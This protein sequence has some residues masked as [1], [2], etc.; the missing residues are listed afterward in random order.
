MSKQIHVL[1]D[2]G[3]GNELAQYM[4]NVASIESMYGCV[5][6][7][8]GESNIYKVVA[9]FEDAGIVE[10]SQV[11]TGSYSVKLNHLLSKA[12][13]EITP[14]VHEN[15]QLAGKAAKRWN[16][17]VVI[18]SQQE[19]LNAAIAK[20]TAPVKDAGI[21]AYS[22][23][24]ESQRTQVQSIFQKTLKLSEPAEINMITDAIDR[25][26][27]GASLGVM[28]KALNLKLD[29]QHGIAIYEQEAYET[30]MSD[31]MFSYL[32]S[33]WES[34]QR[35]VNAISGHKYLTPKAFG[36]ILDTARLGKTSKMSFDI[37]AALVAVGFDKAVSE[38]NAN[39]KETTEY[40]DVKPFMTGDNVC[41][42]I[43]TNSRNRLAGLAKMVAELQDVPAYRVDESQTDMESEDI[44]SCLSIYYEVMEE[45]TNNLMAFIFLTQTAIRNSTVINDVITSIDMVDA[46]ITELFENVKNSA[47]E[48]GV[49]SQEGFKE[50]IGK[51]TNMFN[52]SEVTKQLSVLSDKKSGVNAINN[53]VRDYAANADTL[54][55]LKLRDNHSL[56]ESRLKA[57]KKTHSATISKLFNVSINK[58]DTEA[59]F[60]FMTNAIFVTPVTPKYV[61][62]MGAAIFD[63][64]DKQAKLVFKFLTDGAVMD[65]YLD[66]PYRGEKYGFYDCFDVA[67]SSYEKLINLAMRKPTPAIV[68]ET[69]DNV[70]EHFVVDSHGTYFAT[71]GQLQKLLPG[72]EVDIIVPTIY[73]SPLTGDRNP[74][75]YRNP[76]VPT[77]EGIYAKVEANPKTVLSLNGIS[78]NRD[79]IE[80]CTRQFDYCRYR[81]ASLIAFIDNDETGYSKLDKLHGWIVE[82]AN[83]ICDVIVTCPE[84][85]KR[86][87]DQY[88]TGL[89]G[90]IRDTT[91]CLNDINNRAGLIL[92]VSRTSTETS[93]QLRALYRDFNEIAED[94]IAIAK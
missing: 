27:A 19:K 49:V 80:Y 67:Y 61:S 88:L 68:K 21:P 54:F 6:E 84:I 38:Y 53:I 46:T 44:R 26:N 24:S 13:E 81:D 93:D 28:F 20:L 74:M 11:P 48:D 41:R 47:V 66:V 56:D 92:N 51:I 9:S 37:K 30:L 78:N 25:Y 31:D 1:H 59:L 7:T 94:F 85:S 57:F 52:K 77:F 75:G 17:H 65:K 83:A 16:D 35:L 32:F 5:V 76:T 42:P 29:Y 50:L 60:S 10:S 89:L 18:E 4:R 40:S 45:V 23:M 87:A 36:E 73:E 3:V 2:E 71:A 86:D 91:S 8:I 22:E 62:N 55:K 15:M 58:M 90:I 14:C 34:Y 72:Y 43:S 12:I 63:N 70:L 33:R 64:R 69:V 82:T 39:T 79:I